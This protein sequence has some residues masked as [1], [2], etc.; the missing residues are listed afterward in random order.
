MPKRHQWFPQCKCFKCGVI[1][2]VLMYKRYSD[3]CVRLVCLKCYD[4]PVGRD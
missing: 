1:G 3:G 4:L 2:P